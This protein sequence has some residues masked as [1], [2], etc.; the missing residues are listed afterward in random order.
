MKSFSSLLLL[1]ATSLVG[2]YGQSV[3]PSD[4]AGSIHGIFLRGE[5]P[6]DDYNSNGNT[7]NV[8]RDQVLSGV[9]GS[10][11]NAVPYDHANWVKV[12]GVMNGSDLLNDYVA[13][14]V[15][16]CPNTKIWL[17]GYSLGAD[18]MMNSL[19]GVSSFGLIPTSQLDP[20]YKSNGML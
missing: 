18:A 3:S 13:D 14:Y 17:L 10:T 20:K 6:G 5:G 12:Y 9:P 8:M 2:V 1:L 4:C 19:C 11:V 16:S 7:L 15:S